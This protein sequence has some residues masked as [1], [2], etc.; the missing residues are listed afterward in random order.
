MARPTPEGYVKDCDVCRR[1]M[2]ATDWEPA[3]KGSCGK[4]WNC[5]T[6]NY[7]PGIDLQL[8][9]DPTEADTQP[10]SI[11]D[12]DGLIQKYGLAY[13]FGGPKMPVQVSYDPVLDWW[14]IEKDPSTTIYWPTSYVKWL[15]K[16]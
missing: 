16:Q 1:H 15:S 9:P 13:P 6:Q 12:V 5:G 4:C 11:S 10:V 2:V 8:I 14:K 7:E 3:P